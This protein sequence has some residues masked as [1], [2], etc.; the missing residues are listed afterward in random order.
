MN[1]FAAA[2]EL[3]STLYQ[4]V[5]GDR[6]PGCCSVVSLVKISWWA[7]LECDTG[8]SHA[9]RHR[10]DA[11]PRR[12]LRKTGEHIRTLAEGINR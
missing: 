11:Q 8:R 10:P 4:F 9:G 6:Q 12:A 2:A 3:V 5:P 7:E 1:R